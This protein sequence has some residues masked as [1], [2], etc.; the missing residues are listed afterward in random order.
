VMMNCLSTGGINAGGY[1]CGLFYL[2]NLG[3]GHNGAHVG[4]LSQMAY[5]PQTDFTVVVFTNCWNV[6]DG[7]STM[8]DQLTNLLENNCYKAKQIV[9]AK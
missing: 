8:I 1:G 9:N 7:M 6:K 4:Y 3:Y 5:D 2:N